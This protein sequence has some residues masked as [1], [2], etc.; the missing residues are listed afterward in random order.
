MTD[1]RSNLLLLK[2]RIAAQDRAGI[3]ATAL[4]LIDAAPPLGRQWGAIATILQHH[5]E[6]PAA[7]RAIAAWRA[8]VGDEPQILFECATILAR[9]GRP[10]EAR[11]VLDR[12]P[13]DFPDPVGN[14]YVKGTLA[15]NLGDVDGAVTALQKATALDSASGQS[16][17]ARAM[18]APLEQAEARRLRDAGPRFAGVENEDAAA[19]QYALGKLAD[20]RL[21]HD[22]AFAAFDRG[23][24]IVARRR[25]FD[26]AAD[27]ALADAAI[28]GWDRASIDEARAQLDL[29]G[30]ARPMFVTG[31][32]RS[33]TTLVEQILA[34]HSAVAGGAE[35]GLFGILARDLGGLSHQAFAQWRHRGGEPHALRDL[36]HH[37]GEQ[38]FAGGGRFV[39]KTLATSR[40]L[41]LIAA[42]FPD[43]P[44][45]WL[46]RDPLDCAWSAFRSFFI[47]GVEWSWSL[48]SIADFFI[49]EDRLF[50]HYTRLLGPQ[51]LV[52]PYAE[53]V[54]DPAGWTRRID[55][56]CG[57]ALEEA[58]L[59]PHRT[60]RAVI[61]NSASQV[62]EAIHQRGLG[63]AAP[64]RDQL[65]PFID[66]YARD[67]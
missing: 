64:Y 43:A 42:L 56:H 63:S 20:D 9:A 13:D 54:G 10:E 61:T 19:Y 5:G 66:R 58:Q 14:A 27:R 22:A 38:R 30:P 3:N 29:A 46:R 26:A 12:L 6:H 11:K 1:A 37:L 35:L 33:G 53:M 45:V 39:D 50:D 4:A 51:I 25:P 36:Y 7:L 28:A 57:L 59:S 65:A 21:D 41:G 17:L 15:T 55:D 34:S 49:Q 52:I 23:A 48:E 67:G 2:D 24:R 40:Y 62:R 31:L 32:P 44:I 18:A 8:D 16:W 60:R 47:R